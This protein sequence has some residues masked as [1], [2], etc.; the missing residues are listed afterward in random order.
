MERLKRWLINKLTKHLLP[1]LSN[2]NTLSLD[3]QGHLY[4]D[5]QLMTNQML[6]T[7]QEE[8]K[9]LQESNIWRYLNG[10]LSRDAAKLMFEKSQSLMDLT[11]GKTMLYTLDVQ[12]KIL[13]S[14]N[15]SKSA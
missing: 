13:E 1:T 12:N 2:G 7:L 4:E 3:K 8:V 14:I 6:H 15:K 9:F 10:N 5:G 11:V